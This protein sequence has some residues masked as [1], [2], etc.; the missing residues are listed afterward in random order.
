LALGG[1]WYHVI[2]C[3]GRYCRIGVDDEKDHRKVNQLVKTVD[4]VIKND[5]WFTRRVTGRAGPAGA[6]FIDV[7][8]R[9]DGR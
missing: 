1:E 6:A 8:E 7:V 4:S 9:L 3:R 5:G 2:S